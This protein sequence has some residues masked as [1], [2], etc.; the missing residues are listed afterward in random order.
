M[1]RVVTD[2]SP[3]VVDASH[4]FACLRRFDDSQVEKSDELFV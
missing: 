1:N 4:I 3:V 2:F